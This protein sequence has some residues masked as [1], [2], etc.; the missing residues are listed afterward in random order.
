MLSLPDSSHRST[1]ARFHPRAQESP[2]SF[3]SML[4]HGPVPG[5]SPPSFMSPCYIK[6]HKGKRK[7]N[8]LTVTNMSSAG[9]AKPWLLTRC[10][11]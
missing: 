2:G 5:P 10:H 3:I 1:S 9:R 6:C 11:F 7:N 8:T 4:H